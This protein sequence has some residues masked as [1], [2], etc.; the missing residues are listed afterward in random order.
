MNKSVYR[1]VIAWD[2]RFLIGKSYFHTVC[3]PDAPK[4]A[5]SEE[6]YFYISELGP[7]L[8]C[9]EAFRTQKAITNI[10]NSKVT[11]LFFHILLV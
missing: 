1:I 11:E 4:H 2:L 3:C 5:L 6:T 8:E 7:L 9:P 10:L